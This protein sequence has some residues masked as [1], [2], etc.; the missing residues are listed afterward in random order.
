M[1]SFLFRKP[2]KWRA[3]GG[4]SGNECASAETV[5]LIFSPACAH[6]SCDICT[7]TVLQESARK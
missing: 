1:I 4:D 6:P 7:D 3:T 2:V 5:W